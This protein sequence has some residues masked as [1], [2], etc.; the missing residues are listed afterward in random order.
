MFVCICCVILTVVALPNDKEEAEDEYRPAETHDVERP[1][2]TAR[3]VRHAAAGLRWMD[4]VADEV[5]GAA[6]FQVSLLHPH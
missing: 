1:E 6:V 4:K 5:I 3:F 2:A